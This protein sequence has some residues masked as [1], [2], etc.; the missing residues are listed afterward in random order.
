VRLDAVWPELPQLKSLRLEDCV[1]ENEDLTKI[2]SRATP[3]LQSLSL[4]LVHSPFRKK[5]PTLF[6]DVLEELWIEDCCH[7][8]FNSHFTSYSALRSLHLDWDLFT[9]VVPFTPPNLL[10]I[11]ISV[12]RE[13]AG[14]A[15]N[16]KELEAEILSLD[17]PRL[18]MIQIK[19]QRHYPLLTNKLQLHRKLRLKNIELVIEL[20][21]RGKGE[22]FI[23][24]LSWN[25]FAHEV[26][27]QLVHIFLCISRNCYPH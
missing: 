25:P 2:L 19:G 7:V 9:K 10:C 16:Y 22:H 1:F 15:P 3:K 21:D 18:K 24:S 6:A 23:V 13:D 5:F 4:Y 26:V 12:P 17:L 14:S 8:E 11:S 20:V 27:P